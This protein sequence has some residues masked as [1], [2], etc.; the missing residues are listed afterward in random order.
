MFKSK[1]QLDTKPDPFAQ[2]CTH[3]EVEHNFLWHTTQMYQ[4]AKARLKN[5]N[6]TGVVAERSFGGREQDI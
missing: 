1:D 6:E 2:Q 3:F 4:L 5:H